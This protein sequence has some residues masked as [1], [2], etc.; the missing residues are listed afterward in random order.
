MSSRFRFSESELDALRDAVR[1]AEKGTPGEIVVF[2][3]PRSRSYE[4]VYWRGAG[5][6]VIVGLVAWT[7]VSFLARD[8]GLAW[9]WNPTFAVGLVFAAVLTGALI[10]RVSGSVFRRLAGSELLQRSV[11]QRAQTVFL[12]E[13]VQETAAR[14]G[15]LL[16]FSEL[17]RRIEILADKGINAVVAESKWQEIVNLVAG[18]LADGDVSGALKSGISAC[19]DVLREAGVSATAA[20]QNELADDIRF[21][22]D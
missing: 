1:E 11:R 12:R 16:F 20:D 6:G 17:E 19:G 10:P 3:A 18:R 9:I 4:E 7:L 22:E 21:E 2:V 14:T 13:G 15:I 5:L 8:W